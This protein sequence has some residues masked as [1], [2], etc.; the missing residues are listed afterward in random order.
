MQLQEGVYEIAQGYRAV[1]VDKGTK[2]LI[3]KR[4]A[5]VTECNRCRDC[6]HFLQGKYLFS[7]KQW[8]ESCACDQKIKKIA[9]KDYFY[10]A[11]PGDKACKMFET[12][13]D[14]E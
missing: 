1:I 7:P 8:W 3:V 11:R 13:E 12:K 5:T 9:G 6:K 14:E 4:K 2:V 10:A